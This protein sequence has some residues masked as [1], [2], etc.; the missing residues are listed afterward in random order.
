MVAVT[1][2]VVV[3]AD[4]D[5]YQSED[6]GFRLVWRIVCYWKDLERS[7]CVSR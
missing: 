1:V 7:E 2:L 5:N 4:V 3:F 6:P